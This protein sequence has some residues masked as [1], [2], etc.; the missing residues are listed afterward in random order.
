MVAV[1]KGE[2]SVSGWCRVWWDKSF[3]S[4]RKVR[5]TPLPTDKVRRRLGFG[6][7]GSRD[8]APHVAHNGDSLSLAGGQA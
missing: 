5:V 8:P 6:G 1:G 7:R 3:D 4:A 2:A